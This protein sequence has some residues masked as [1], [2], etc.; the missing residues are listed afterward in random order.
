MFS[1]SIFDVRSTCA[2]KQNIDLLFRLT[3]HETVGV[4]FFNQQIMPCK[5]LVHI[6][7]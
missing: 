5:Y 1:K 7:A 4:Y 6:F 2:G 3:A